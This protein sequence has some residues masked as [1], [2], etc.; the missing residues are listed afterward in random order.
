MLTLFMVVCVVA[1]TG[2]YLWSM[3]RLRQQIQQLDQRYRQGVVEGY[4][5]PM[6]Q[7]MPIPMAITDTDTGV[8]IAANQ[9]IMELFELDGSATGLQ[10]VDY[11]VDPTR[12]HAFVAQ[13]KSQGWVHGFEVEMRSQA[14]RIFWVAFSA[15]LT[16]YQ[17]RLVTVVVVEDI[18]GRRTTE[19][20]LKRSEINLRN[21]YE[22]VPSPMAITALADGLVKQLNPAA[23]RLFGVSDVI[24]TP[25]RATDYYVNPADRAR[26]LEALQRRGSVD[27]FQLQ[28]YDHQG[29]IFD[30]IMS[31]APVEYNGAPHL[32]TSFANI[33][34]QKVLERE[35][36]DAKAMAE[37]ADRAKSEFLA[38]MSHEIRTPLN[39]ALTM[40]HLLEQTSLD[41]EQQGYLAAINYSGEALLTLLNDVLDISKIEAGSLVVVEE[42]FAIRPLVVDMVHLLQVKA[43]ENQTYIVYEIDSAIP[44]MLL[45]DA[46]RLR[47]ILFNLLGNAI[48]FT[49]GGRVEVRVG[50]EPASDPEAVALLFQVIDNGV[51]VA[52]EVQSQLFRPFFQADSTI[53][54]RYG[55]TGLGLVICHRLVTL[56]G[57]TIGVESGRRDG[58]QFWFRL[59]MRLWKPRVEEYAP[60][61][62]SP[63]LKQPLNILLVED[64][65]INQL[66][67]SSLLRREGHRVTVADS[68]YQALELLAQWAPESGEALF[69]LVLMDIRMPGLDGMETTRR[70]RQYPPPVGVLPVIA[71]TADVTSETLK[72]CDAVGMD[73]VISKPFNPKELDRELAR[74]SRGAVDGPDR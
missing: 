36:T 66:A 50:R 41:P 71:L 70:I 27:D 53:S 4:L 56:L 37:D 52:K 28:M 30:L 69:D 1:M 23:V 12:R 63:A 32:L 14:G 55:G 51:G 65:A 25:L 17:G 16:R 38:T 45:G 5:E 3:R 10:V 68:G 74:F 62:A 54:R 29:E 47:Q 18:D 42:G 73:R 21:V 48:K 33:T 2:F 39:G 35:L 58:S 43:D 40:A 19:Q 60:V 9:L 44:P 64:D 49:P 59:T 22:T 11:Y 20:A 13:V 31:A 61:V 46:S 67:E 6:I 15:S 57:G 72:A 26:L 24:N 7:L 8:T 34:Q